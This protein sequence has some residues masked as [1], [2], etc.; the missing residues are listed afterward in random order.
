MTKYVIPVG[1]RAKINNNINRESRHYFWYED[2]DKVYFD[3]V[4]IQYLDFDYNAV[5]QEEFSENLTTYLSSLGKKAKKKSDR[6]TSVYADSS[7][8]D[9]R[10]FW[11][12]K[13]TIN[14]NWEPSQINYYNSY[15]E[16]TKIYSDKVIQEDIAYNR[17]E[18]WYIQKRTKNIKRI[19]E[20]EVEADVKTKE[21]CKYYD[22]EQAAKMGVEKRNNLVIKIKTSTIWLLIQTGEATTIAEAEAEWIPFLASMCLSINHYSAGD[23]QPL[24]DAITNDITHTW[25][26]NDIGWA[27]TIR[28][29]ILSVI[30][31]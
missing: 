28:Q 16:D 26:D 30:D 5:F 14:T 20:D 29:Y 11:L 22:M 12:K 23:T 18:E 15:D 19:N 13:E 2:G 25:L 10:L 27:V 31:Y 8:A 7:D 1:D 6:Y 24:V 21:L 4:V 9:Y 17:N 3:E